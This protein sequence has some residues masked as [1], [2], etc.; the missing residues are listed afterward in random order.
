MLCEIVVDV[1]VGYDVQD[2]IA[3]TKV[4]VDDVPDVHVKDEDP[5]A[6]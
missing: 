1:D 3:V 5:D 2:E 6:G 4:V